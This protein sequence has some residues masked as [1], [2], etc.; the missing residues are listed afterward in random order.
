MLGKPAW[1]GAATLTGCAMDGGQAST[2]QVDARPGFLLIDEPVSLLYSGGE[3][4]APGQQA[5]YLDLATYG[6][7]FRYYFRSVDGP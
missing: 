6:V 3:K 2:K 7:E 1:L 5:K 4:L